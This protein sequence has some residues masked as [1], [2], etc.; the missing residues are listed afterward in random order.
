MH[1]ELRQDRPNV[2]VLMAVDRVMLTIAFDVHADI[3]WGRF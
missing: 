2:P 3:A 1:S